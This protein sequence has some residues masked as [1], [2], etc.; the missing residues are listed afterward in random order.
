MAGERLALPGMREVSAVCTHPAYTGRGYAAMLVQH[1][2]GT[3]TQAGLRT[4]L[5]AS[6]SNTRAVALYE[7]LGFTMTRRL[8]FRS[9]QRMDS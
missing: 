7:R 5:H 8:L 4:L 1:V 6:A 9:V 3:H 2:V